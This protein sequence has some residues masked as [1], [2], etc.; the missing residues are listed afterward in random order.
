MRLLPPP[1]LTHTQNGALELR[2]ESRVRSPRGDA[3]S[4]KLGGIM[5][6]MPRGKGTS[7]TSSSTCPG[8]LSSVMQQASLLAPLRARPA[9]GGMENTLQVL[10]KGP[11]ILAQARLLPRRVLQSAVKRTS[12]PSAPGF[13]TWLG[14]SRVTICGERG[15]GEGEGAS[16]IRSGAEALGQIMTQL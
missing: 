6:Y 9:G 4:I 16:T 10:D 7:Y 15:E 5:C 1:L 2:L 11:S 8:L 3:I 12:C 14:S 13:N